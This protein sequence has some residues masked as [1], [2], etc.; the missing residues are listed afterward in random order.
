MDPHPHPQ[1]FP[2][3]LK[4]RT[5][6]IHPQGPQR[7]PGPPGDQARSLPHRHQQGMDP[8]LFRPCHRLM[9]R[10]AVQMGKRREAA[11]GLGQHLGG[12]GPWHGGAWEN[13][14]KHGKTLGIEGLNGELRFG[15]CDSCDMACVKTGESLGAVPSKWPKG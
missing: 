6:Q 10:R 14:G 3:I 15:S 13:M 9:P 2:V 5:D 1:S 8:G 12:H 4:N 7:P 11:T